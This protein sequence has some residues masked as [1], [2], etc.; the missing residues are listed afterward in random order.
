MPTCEWC[1]VCD[2]SM[3]RQ[4]FRH[5]DFHP[6]IFPAVVYHLFT[7]AHT[8]GCNPIHFSHWRNLNW[9]IHVGW[10]LTATVSHSMGFVPKHSSYSNFVASF[11]LTQSGMVRWET[12]GTILLMGYCQ[13]LLP[14]SQTMLS[15]KVCD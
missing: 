13:K 8:I 12:T 7:D 15:T 11:L 2:L 14:R 10:L 5:Q 1:C 4:V 9:T 6:F 3:R